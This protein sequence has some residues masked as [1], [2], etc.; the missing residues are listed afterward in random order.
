MLEGAQGH[1]A[2][3]EKVSKES[4]VAVKNYE[5][6][7]KDLATAVKALEEENR[8]LKDFVYEINPQARF[9]THKMP[10]A[11]RED[12]NSR[13]TSVNPSLLPTSRNAKQFM[14]KLDELTAKA[15]QGKGISKADV[16]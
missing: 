3:L 12:G 10:V 13:E 11:R 14:A 7:I 9:A 1:N 16:C 15:A 8:L 2:V 4:A 6:Q 5:T